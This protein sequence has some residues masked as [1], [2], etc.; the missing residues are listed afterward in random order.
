MFYRFGGYSIYIY[1]CV[2]VCILRCIYIYVCVLQNSQTRGIFVQTLTS[3][4]SGTSILRKAAC[5]TNLIEK[6]MMVPLH[7]PLGA[8][9]IITAS[10]YGIY[11][12]NFATMCKLDF[13]I[14][15][16]ILLHNNVQ[17]LWAASRYCLFTILCHSHIIPYHFKKKVNL[18]LAGVVLSPG[19]N[20]T[21]M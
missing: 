9:Y 21:G 10:K 11:L 20:C 18:D 4:T 5:C 14:I 3:T 8:S 15:V 6:L 7:Q 19:S 13:V 2:C 17:N 12:T 1:M 16:T